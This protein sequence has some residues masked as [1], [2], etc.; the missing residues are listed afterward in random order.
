VVPAAQYTEPAFTL[1]VTFPSL[2]VF[3]ALVGRR[4]T[5]PATLRLLVGVLVVDVTV[6]ATDSTNQT[7]LCEIPRCEC[8]KPP[9]GRYHTVWTGSVAA[10][11]R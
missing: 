5:M 3:N 7:L 1:I 2:C 9:I 11:K 10:R 8:S 4:L 6:A